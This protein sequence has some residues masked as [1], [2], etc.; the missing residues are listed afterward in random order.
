VSNADLLVATCNLAD[1]LFDAAS[2][3]AEALI[4]VD[5]ERELSDESMKVERGPDGGL[6][7]IGKVGIDEAVGEYVGI[8]MARGAP[9]AA[10]RAHLECFV[11]RPECADE[12]YEGAVG[13]SAADGA[14]WRIWPMPSGEWVEID[15]DDDL[16]RARTLVSLP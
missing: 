9:L 7:R 15:D 4:C 11:G 6:A 2:A 1:F 10:M 5:L 16:A 8:L 14:S 3:S 13:R 12:W